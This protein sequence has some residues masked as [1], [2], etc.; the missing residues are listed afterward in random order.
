M[1]VSILADAGDRVVAISPDNLTGNTGWTQ[2]AETRVTSHT[3][4]TLDEVFENLS[5]SD[6]IPIYKFVDGYVEERTAEEIA[7]DVAEIPVDD[8]VSSDAAIAEILEVLNDD[9]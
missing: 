4:K 2:V 6:G 5:N 3:M 1:K 9:T 7:A 8:S